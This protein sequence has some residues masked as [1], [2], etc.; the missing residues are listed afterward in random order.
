MAVKSVMSQSMKQEKK[1]PLQ[2]L[3]RVLVI[4]GLVILLL[5]LIFGIIKLVPKAFNG[6]NDWGSNIFSF[7][8]DKEIVNVSAN[9]NMVKAGDVAV[10]SW[11][12]ENENKDGWF[13]L[14]YSCGDKT[15]YIDQIE[16]GK[17]YVLGNATSTNR[18]IPIRV[19]GTSTNSINLT[20]TISHRKPD[21]DD[22][23]AE[24]FTV[25][26]VNPRNGVVVNTSNNFQ[27]ATPTPTQTSGSNQ[28]YYNTPIPSATP[29]P[30][31]R[32]SY[33]YNTNYNYNSSY[34]P[35]YT[36]SYSGPSDLTAYITSVQYSGAGRVTVNF[37][38]TNTGYS[39]TGPWQFVAYLPASLPYE[40]I[41][42][43][44]YQSSIPPGKTSY[45]NLSF[46]PYYGGGSAEIKISLDPENRVPELNETNNLAVNYLNLNQYYP[47]YYQNQNYYSNYPYN[48]NYNSNYPYPT[49]YP[50]YQYPYNYNNYNYN[51][52]NYPYNYQYP[53][54]N[55]NNCYYNYQY[56]Y[57][58]CP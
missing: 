29:T 33:S 52:N 12:L 24:G 37:Q 46:Y 53:S 8:Q 34:S 55:Y 2:I 22:K 32:P 48:S 31:Y 7:G 35:S 17:P 47:S 44:A 4:L 5:L 6:F 20:V 38:V 54:N 16:C 11:N 58:S 40:S 51:Y 23:Y 13:T 27:N 21:S 57:T 41:Y 19:M 45:F 1:T 18:S 49:Y 9:P 25:V 28:N 10:I 43:S 42:N 56:G 15:L 50:N 30:T 36:Y 26:A 14:Q 3:V 39:P